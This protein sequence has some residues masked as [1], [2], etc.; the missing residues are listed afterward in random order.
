MASRWQRET[1]RGATARE[2]PTRATSP[3][4]IHIHQRARR[5]FTQDK[6]LDL[7]TGVARFK[8]E[9]EITETGALPSYTPATRKT[10]GKPPG[11]GT[12]K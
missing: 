3:A 9:P 8:D 1:A 6:C 7:S 5:Y 12:E 4:T 2:T 11:V 10:G